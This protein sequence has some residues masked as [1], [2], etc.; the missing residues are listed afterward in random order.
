M[1]TDCEKTAIGPQNRMFHVKHDSWSTI[2]EKAMKKCTG[3]AD[4]HSNRMFHVKYD[5]GGTISEK[6]Q[7]L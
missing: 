3:A 1:L 7:T 4:G 2:P 6:M 5:K